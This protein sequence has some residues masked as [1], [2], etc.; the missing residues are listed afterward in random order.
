MK[1]ESKEIWAI[2]LNVIPAHMSIDQIED[3]IKRN[4]P[5]IMAFVRRYGTKL[6]YLL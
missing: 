3:G 4:T 6:T 2:P 1:K 5:Y